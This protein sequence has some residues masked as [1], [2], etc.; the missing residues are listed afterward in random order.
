MGAAAISIPEDLA[1]RAEAIPGLAERVVSYIRMEVSQYEQRQKR[2]RPETL[3]LVERARQTAESRRAEGYDRD[4]AMEE[5]ET[6]YR[7]LVSD[8]PV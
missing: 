2:F 3:D 5:F 7:R 4:A 8:E 6:R 1:A